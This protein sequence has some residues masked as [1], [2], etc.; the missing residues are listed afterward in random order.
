MLKQLYK[1][2]AVWVIEH[3][4]FAGSPMYLAIT[5]YADNPQMHY[6]LMAFSA[7]YMFL[8]ALWL[9]AGQWDLGFEF[10]NFYAH[11]K[12]ILPSTFAL[13]IIIVLLKQ[14]NLIAGGGEISLGQTLL[15]LTLSVPLQELVFRSFCVWRC[16][17]SWNSIVFITIFTSANFAFYHLMFGTWELVIG[18][19]LLNLFWQ[20]W[21]IRQRN[22][23][24]IA[25]SHAILGLAY[26]YF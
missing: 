20:F 16:A 25:I 12:A 7:A 19:F 9:S 8:V 10:K 5:K 4:L 22:V 11:L 13:G 23:T 2:K 15:Y 17:L 1:H 26:F 24:V 21:Y 6:L 14:F 3:V 18:V